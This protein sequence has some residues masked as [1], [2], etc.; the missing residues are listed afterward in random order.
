MKV[1]TRHICGED[2]VLCYSLRVTKA[3]TERFGTGGIREKLKESS[4][5]ETLDAVVWMLTL[6]MAAGKRYADKNGIPARLL[7]AKTI[8]SIPTALTIWKSFTA[9]LRTPWLQVSSRA[10]RRRQKTPGPGR[11]KRPL[12][13]AD[14]VRAPPGPDAG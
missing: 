4:T 9:P 3:V 12:C 7:P 5:A 11:G 2:R 13:L 8:C 6:M 1:I 14:L 10:W